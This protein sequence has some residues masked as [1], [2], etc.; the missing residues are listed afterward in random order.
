M[1]NGLYTTVPACMRHP[2]ERSPKDL[3]HKA[4]NNGKCS[5]VGTFLAT[6]NHGF[7]RIVFW[8]DRWPVRVF[9]WARHQLVAGKAAHDFNHGEPVN[10]IFLNRKGTVFK[11][12]LIYPI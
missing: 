3:L 10:H 1:V 4:P 7:S 9:G 6:D 2:E 8:P 11:V 5:N 12:K